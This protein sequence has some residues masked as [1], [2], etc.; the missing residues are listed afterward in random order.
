MKYIIN[1]RE[2]TKNKAIRGIANTPM[3]A[4]KWNVYACMYDYFLSVQKKENRKKERMA[5][6]KTHNK[7]ITVIVV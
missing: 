2:T 7:K 1:P 6:I 5:R 4:I 3:M